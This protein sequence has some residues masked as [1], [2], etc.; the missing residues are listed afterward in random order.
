MVAT[1]VTA[2]DISVRVATP[3]DLEA[4]S[5][6]L[7]ASYAALMPAGYP[8]DVLA[9]ALPLITVAKPELLASG[10]YFVATVPDAPDIVGCGG[11]T[12]E[13]PCRGAVEP[14]L[15]HI[16]HFATDP[17]LVGCGVGR[18]I[19]NAA[20]ASAAEHGIAVLEVYASL[21]AVP[22]YAAMGF[23]GSE[24]NAVMLGGQVPFESRVMRRALP[25]G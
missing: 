3:A 21:N 5:G 4:V 13:R 11:W 12:P 25:V 8:A 19:M 24:I 7:A 2:A 22:F 6:L 16:R 15:G 20:V 9:V 17:R 18:T 1:V 14:G 10:T 23:S